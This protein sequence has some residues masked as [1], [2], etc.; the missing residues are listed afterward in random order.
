LRPIIDSRLLLAAIVLAEELHYGRAAQRLHIAVSTLSKQIA[1]LEE[2]LG[3]ILFVRNSKVV[4]LTEAGRAYV[5]EARASL[6]HAEK[7]VNV[8]RAA[9]DG[10]EH[11]L[12]AGHT[13]YTDPAFKLMLLSIHLP[14]FPNTKVRLQSDFTFDLVHSLLAAELDLALVAW[15][16]EGA[17]LTLV[18]IAQAPL[19]VA[20]PE[21]HPASGRDE[22]TLPDLANDNWILFSKRVHPLLYDAIFRRSREYSIMPKEVHHVV[23]PEEAIRL[24]IEHAGVALTAR[25]AALSNRQPGVIMKPLGEAQLIVKTYLALRANESSRMVNEFARAFL[26]KCA[27]PSEPDSQLK[28]PIN[29]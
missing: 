28:L 27:P 18:E 21:S 12:T 16:P 1:L 26:R 8:A 15:P 10:L 2:K 7:A 6:L 3:F 9:N 20:L 13:P 25:S 22:I 17:A 4:E 24:V 19:Y 29:N 5:E 23:T 14:L 11:I